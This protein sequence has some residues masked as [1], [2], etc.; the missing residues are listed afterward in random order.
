M[1]LASFDASACRCSPGRACQRA[2]SRTMMP[3]RRKC[4][5]KSYNDPSCLFRDAHQ[6]NW[7]WRSRLFSLSLRM[8]H[9]GIIPNYLYTWRRFF[10][11]L[12]QPRT[13]ST[14]WCL[15]RLAELHSASLKVLQQQCVVK[16]D[17][18]CDILEEAWT[19]N[20]EG[21]PERDSVIWLLRTGQH[22]DLLL[23]RRLQKRK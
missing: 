2:T 11:F 4:A 13:Y 1:V 21:N 6:K 18:V 22:Y 15:G 5:C 20:G 8:N 12:R 23:P 3:K 17:V 14:S 19:E 9:C 10:E 7:S 16:G